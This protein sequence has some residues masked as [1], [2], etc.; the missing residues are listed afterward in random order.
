VF[1]D[2]ETTGLSHKNAS[3]YLIGVVYPH[4]G[5]WQYVQWFAE[6]MQEEQEILKAFLDFI[7]SYRT[8]VH[9]N[10]T[11][12]DLPFLKACAKEYHL[13][14]E[15]EKW[16]Q[17]D[18]YRS[19]K[20]LGSFL[21]MKEMK[22]PVLETRFGLN[23]EDQSTGK[24][25]IEVYRQYE[26]QPSPD[27]QKKLLLHNREDLEG[28]L[29][30][31]DGLAYEQILLGGMN[32]LRWEKTKEQVSLFLRTTTKLA[33]PSPAAYT[34]QD[35]HI[36]MEGQ[37]LQIQVECHEDRVRFF[38]TDYKNYLYL[39]GED[40]AVHKRVGIYVDAACR[41]KATRDNAYQWTPLELLLKDEKQCNDYV[42][43]LVKHYIF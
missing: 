1:F 33:V 29:V 36:R 20:P 37:E 32:L 13:S 41:E 34:C 12:F 31:A 23:R 17:L 21:G 22:Q 8:L 4:E 7:G 43:R 42:H 38:F 30:V 39:P 10:G 40:R 35:F 3:L 11:T 14:F 25:L 28:M 24:E 18:L 26:K 2:I 5:G 6:K 27:L 16:A 19:L 15:P 9:F